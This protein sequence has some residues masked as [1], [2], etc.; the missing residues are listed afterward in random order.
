MELDSLSDAL[1]LVCL[2][3]PENLLT[4]RSLLHDLLALVTATESLWSKNLRLS[5]AF[6]AT[7][8]LFV[9]RLPKI[10]QEILLQLFDP[11]TK[12]MGPLAKLVLAPTKQR[13]LGKRGK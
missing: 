3:E 7:V 1:Q 6:L 5:T 8:H 4:R 11:S 12:M 13:R 9:A 2:E 10:E